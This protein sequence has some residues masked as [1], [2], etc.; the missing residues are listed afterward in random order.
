[1]V[2]I[3]YVDDEPGLL[4]IG[5]IF[6]ERM[7]DLRVDTAPSARDAIE[8][9]NGRHYDCIVSDYQMPEMDGL[10]FLTYVRHTWGSTPFILFTGKGRED[11]VI[12]ALNNGADFYLQKGGDPKPQ[13]VELAHKIRLAVEKNRFSKQILDSEKRLSDIINFLPDATFAIDLHGKVIA[14]NRAIEEMTG[15]RQ[16]Q[17]LGMGDFI[18]S[19]YV[20]GEK[21]PLLIDH[22]LHNYPEI[23]SEYPF[24]QR[25]G[26]NLISERY[27]SSFNGGKGAHLWLIA[28][29]LYDADGKIAGAIE[30]LRD[31]TSRKMAEE[32]VRAAF[33]QLTATEEE[34]RQQYEDLARSERQVRD[35]ERRLSDIINFLPDA[36]FAIDQN[37]EVIAWNNAIEEMTGVKRFDILGSGDYS[38]S[39]PFYGKRRP[40]LID[41]ALKGETNMGDGYLSVS[42]NGESFISEVH[43][44]ALYGGKGAHIWFTA[45]R[46]YDADG[47]VIGAIESIRD[48]TDKTNTLD[49]LRASYEQLA[50]TEEEL[51]QQYRDLA[52][53]EKR[54]REDERFM[55]D[56]FSSIQDGIATLDRDLNIIQ[57]NDA[58]T[59]VSRESGSLTGKQCYEV[60]HHKNV[61]CKDCPA[62]LTLKTGLPGQ[63]IICRERTGKNPVMLDVFTYPLFDSVAGEIT[64]VIEYVRGITDLMREEAASASPQVPSGTDT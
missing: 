40:I 60:F 51:R 62:I 33:E 44:P 27:I 16:D 15:I 23:I 26:N 61:P 20:F 13:F 6:L 50:A 22:V 55:R 28:S 25:T 11:V 8:I 2:S 48:V 29:P 41:T 24:L 19:Q 35:N 47:R 9:L 7:G 53:G 18:Y 3:L 4:D 56:L 54:I 31:I 36:T 34:L 37:G 58:M 10:A 30:S 64:G 42:R 39:L 49:E 32:E 38:Y 59:Q 5:K 43:V 14:W 57:V 52:W 12:E 63:K 46:L 17:V 45:S 21:R 1:M